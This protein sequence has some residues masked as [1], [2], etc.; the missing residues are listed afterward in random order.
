MLFL[1]DKDTVVLVHSMQ[2][3][4]VTGGVAPPILYVST[5]WRSQGNKTF[6]PIYLR[7]KRSDTQGRGGK[8]DPRASPDVVEKRKLYSPTGI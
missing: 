5:I 3:Y 6:L 4:M 1:C 7:R 2:V 8:V